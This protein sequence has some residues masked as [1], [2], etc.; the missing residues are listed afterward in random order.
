MK[1]VQ[2]VIFTP[3]ECDFFIEHLS[4]NEWFSG[5][6]YSDSEGWFDDNNFSRRKEK[7]I[8]LDDWINPLKCTARDFWTKKMSHWVRNFPQQ[9]KLL[10]Y[11]KGD[12]L[13]RHI[14]SG[15]GPILEQRQWSLM[16][17]LND[18]SEYTGG[19]FTVGDFIMPKQKGFCCLFNGGSVFHEVKPVTSGTRLS[20][21]TWFA[22]SDL[23]FL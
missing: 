17:Q 10:K 6:A 20:F 1:R 21:I 22:E 19:D 18:E 11:N 16:V 15:K 7:F 5:Q 2:G 23:T 4:K 14:D 9:V 3:E 12:F 13:K 8:D